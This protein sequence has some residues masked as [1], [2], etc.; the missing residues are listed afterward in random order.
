MRLL[1]HSF[2]AASAAV[3]FFWAV[4]AVAAA[5]PADPCAPLAPAAEVYAAFAAL[6]PASL[7]GRLLALEVDLAASA[8]FEQFE[9]TA[10]GAFSYGMRFNDVAEGWSWQP[11]ARPQDEDYYRWKFLP[12]G[13]SHEE[14]AAY[15]Q[16]E[17][18]GVPQRTRIE[19]RHDYFLA[20]DN[21]YA[22]YARGA[23]GFAARLP[24]GRTLRLVALARLTEP[25]LAASTTY[26][27]AVHA[28]PVDLTL[29]KY[30]L[31]GA[32]QALVI[33]D[34]RS[35]EEL[36]RIVPMPVAQR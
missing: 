8:G 32:L 3:L 29:K 14:G 31:I 23:A 34:A 9:L 28:Q 16:E 27:K 19:R 20:F 18:I 21:P 13:S 12:L 10:D 25:A 1:L 30:Y 35:G 17:K 7:P 22:F 33:C 5:S 6:P 11:Q 24:A 2:S 4:P 36:A 15:V 26:W